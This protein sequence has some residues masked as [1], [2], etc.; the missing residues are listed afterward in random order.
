VSEIV[1]FE[2][3]GNQI[4]V[5]TIN[6]VPW[7]VLKDICDA[8]G[9]G[10]PSAVAQRVPEDEKQ[11]VSLN[12][13]SVDVGP[14][15][16]GRQPW[17]VSEPG[18]YRVVLRSDKPA[19]EPFVRFVVHDVL[20]EV[21]ETGMYVAPVVRQQLPGADK[22]LELKLAQYQAK[23]D[24]ELMRKG[25]YRNTVTGQIEPLPG[26]VQEKD[27]DRKL[28]EHIA[29]KTRRANRG[30]DSPYQT[31]DEQR[32]NAPWEDNLGDQ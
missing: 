32:R 17:V 16:G 22:P 5:V 19:A 20:P 11:Q 18:M 10:N 25:L 13:S 7:F 3:D 24:R 30:A 28:D 23:L 12:L 1:P 4:R 14:D 9:L 6:G 29:R 31:R 27:I 2:F 21:R 8:L 15:Q 26:T